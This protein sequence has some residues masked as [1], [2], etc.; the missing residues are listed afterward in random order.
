MAAR[1]SLTRPARPKPRAST[2][3]KAATPGAAPLAQFIQPTAEQRQTCGE[4]IAH[5]RHNT[6]EAMTARN[7]PGQPQ[8]SGNIEQ[9]RDKALR[10]GKIDKARG[11]LPVTSRRHFAA[12]DRNRGSLSLFGGEIRYSPSQGIPEVSV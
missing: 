9:R 4:V 2:V 5:D 1:P 7:R 11:G 8:V 6:F 10:C 12:R 3:R